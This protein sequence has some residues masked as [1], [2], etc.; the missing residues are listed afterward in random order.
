VTGDNASARRWGALALVLVLAL[1]AATIGG[2]G[3]ANSA[4]STLTW[5]ACGGGFDCTTVTVPVDY[6]SPG[7]D[8]LD[9]AV[10]RRKARDPAKRIGVL[11]MNP[12]GPGGSAVGY[13]RSVAAHLAPEIRDRFDIIGFD[14]RG[15]GDSSS[16]VC[17]A[18]LQT[19]FGL[20]GD[21]DD[22]GEWAAIDSAARTF[23]DGCARKYASLLPHIGTRN[24]AR[25][26]DQV[27]AALGEQQ[28]TYVGLSYGT[29]IGAVYADMFPDRVRA[30][31]LDG[32]YDFYSVSGEEGLRLQ[33][34]AFERALDAY[35]ADCRATKCPL[36]NGGA[37]PRLTLD[38]LLA[39]IDAH[40]LPSR[41]ADRPARIGEAET[42]LTMA[43][44]NQSFWGNLSSALERALAGDGS[45]LVFL[46]D[47]YLD[48][49]G[50][51]Y[52]NQTEIYVGVS[53][54]D[55]A[56]P[57]SLAE[58]QA[59]APRHRAASPHFGVAN[60]LTSAL[61]CAYWSA[62]SQPLTAPVAAAAPPIV[63]VATTN[64]PATP[65]DQGVA[66]SKQLRTGI[67][68]THVGE[69]HTVYGNG[70][71]CVDRTVNAYLTQ[72]KTFAAGSICTDDISALLPPLL[73]RAFVPQV[74]REP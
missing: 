60:L 51:D 26:M 54:L 70:N 37:D 39:R 28:I 20:D 49:E 48:R 7:A 10:V 16:L 21:P 67:L 29:T 46:A 2:H 13:V 47:A 62:P 63:V 41:S 73:Q 64:D 17:H 5:K 8:T 15:V 31:V 33:S 53:C 66:V 45:L 9:L 65:Y 14:P 44:Y 11:L 59:L 69:G 36:A 52:S 42:A 34:A 55:Y 74:R 25:D 3:R 23:A 12:G 27:R 40:P 58:F 57:R 32:A 30:M 35:L 1:A 50:D 4:Q 19:L 72:L 61:A 18:N 38:D 6:A 22:A 24:V 68:L 43:L 56:W 71:P